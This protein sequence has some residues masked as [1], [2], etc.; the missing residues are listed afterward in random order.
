MDKT[1][2]YLVKKSNELSNERSEIASAYNQN[3][4]IIS[5]TD[6]KISEM[7]TV[8]DEAMEM[9]SPKFREDSSF[10][11]HEVKELE[12]K[13]VALSQQ[14]EEL[15]GKVKMLENEI[16]LI[17]LCIDEV[18]LYGDLSNI[19]ET[20]KIDAKK[21]SE[22]ENDVSRE[23]INAEQHNQKLKQIKELVFENPYQAVTEITKLIK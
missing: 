10:N 16:K 11:K 21:Q 15:L 23:T 20:N 2:A 4:I 3:Q 7:K 14:N 17:N 8:S 9:F 12:L 22:D 18:E 6:K 19:K 1:K 5:E 13:I